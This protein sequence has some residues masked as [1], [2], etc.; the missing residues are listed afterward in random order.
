M[1]KRIS[2]YDILPAS[3]LEKIAEV[4]S[5]K[6]NKSLF[7]IVDSEEKALLAKK[8]L[9]IQGYQVEIEPFGNK[10]KVIAVVPDK[11]KFEEAINSGAFQKLAWGRYSFQRESAIGMFKYDFDDG[12]IWKTM[13]GEDGEEYLVKEVD[14][15][16]EDNVVRNKVASKTI[17]SI[18]SD[19]NVKNVVSILYDTNADNDLVND[20]VNGFSENQI[21]VHVHNA[22]DS[23]LNDLIANKIEKNQFIQTPE[24]IADVKSIIKVAI[25]NND[26]KTSG[27]LE[28]L[29]VAYTNQLITKTGKMNK[30]FD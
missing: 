19:N 20:M 5:K 29:I 2:D 24:Y 16:D 26:V 22:L 3:E 23:K 8:Q 18:V 14:E 13:V 25:D 27:Q 15:T 10:F 6:E 30:L 12:S 9:K 4:V 11:V 7:D 17:E 21:K 28:E 1:I